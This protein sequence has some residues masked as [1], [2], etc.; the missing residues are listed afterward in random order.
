MG[1]KAIVNGKRGSIGLAQ[2]EGRSTWSR[3]RINKKRMLGALGWLSR[4]SVFL[5]LMS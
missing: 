5:Q 2:S 1:F 3:K 4:L